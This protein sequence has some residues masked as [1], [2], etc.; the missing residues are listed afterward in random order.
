MSLTH[1]AYSK[2][3]RL[4]TTLLVKIRPNAEQWMISDRGYRLMDGTHCECMVVGGMH[5]VVMAVSRHVGLM[6]RLHHLTDCR[7]VMSTIRNQFRYLA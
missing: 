1:P 4:D 5:D 3:L 7:R 6:K 2:S